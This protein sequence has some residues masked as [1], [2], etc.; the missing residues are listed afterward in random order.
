MGT[1]TYAE[2]V[3]GIRATIA[4]YTQALDDGRIFIDYLI[5][6]RSGTPRRFVA[7][8]REKILCAPGNSVERPTIFSARNLSVGRS[9]LRE[10]AILGQRDHALE[11]GIVSLEPAEVH[12]RELERR[13]FS[14]PH[15]IRQLGDW[16]KRETLEIRRN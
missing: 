11:N 8:H 15:E 10:S 3:E 1:T 14:S 5:L 13:N 7:A 9:R 4:R 12:L 16:E 6:V 2:V